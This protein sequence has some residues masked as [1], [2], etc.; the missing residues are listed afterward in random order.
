MNEIATASF[1]GMLQSKEKMFDNEIVMISWFTL[2]CPALP[3]L[4]LCDSSKVTNLHG[5]KTQGQVK[6]IH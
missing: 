5:H 1:K 3:V 6:P 4:P 2:E